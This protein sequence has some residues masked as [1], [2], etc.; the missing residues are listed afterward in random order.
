MVFR[1]VFLHLSE[2][3]VNPKLHQKC[4]GVDGDHPR[5]I[6]DHLW[7]IL[8]HNR[9]K[10]ILGEIPTT[11]LIKITQ[12]YP[13]LGAVIYY[14]SIPVDGLPI[15]DSS[16]LVGVVTQRADAW[17]APR[18]FPYP[19]KSRVGLVRPVPVST[20]MVSR[21]CVCTHVVL[22]RGPVWF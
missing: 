22:G 14:L 19:L 18:M 3:T 13:L 16:F 6:L 15:S 11:I 20:C 8:E 21:I 12:S 4:L 2:N 1:H 9:L 5:P 7:A 17:G 10:T